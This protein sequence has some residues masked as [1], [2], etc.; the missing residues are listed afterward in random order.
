MVCKLIVRWSI[1]EVIAPLM[2]ESLS[3][4]PFVFRHV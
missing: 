4:L 2:S 3:K 1:S